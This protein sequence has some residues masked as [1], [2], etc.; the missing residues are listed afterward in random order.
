MRKGGERNRGLEEGAEDEKAIE[1]K[2]PLDSE[3]DYI[4][5]VSGPHIVSSFDVSAYEDCLQPS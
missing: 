4:S 2:G 3:S 5:D 1:G